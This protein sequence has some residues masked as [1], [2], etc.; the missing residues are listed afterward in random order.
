MEK[1][2]SR[3]IKLMQSKNYQ[4]M[5]KSELAR[6][7]QI[8][9]DERSKMRS[10][11]RK[12][13]SEGEIS[14]GKK[15][16]FEL[17]KNRKSHLVGTLKFHPK[18]FAWVYLDKRNQGNIDSGF[19]MDKNDRVKVSPRHTGVAMDD[20]RVEVKVERT[21][22]PEWVQHVNRRRG[23]KHVKGKKGKG[24]PKPKVSE[25][26]YRDEASGRV[27]KILERRNPI[28]IGTYLE[29]R[30][31]KFVQPESENL[32]GTVELSEPTAAKSGQVV[33]VEMLDWSNRDAMPVGRVTK[34]LGWPDDP[35][36]DI[37]SV[38]HKHG[39]QT[40]FPDAVQK[41]AASVPEVLP[42][43][44]IA[45]RE[46]WRKELI[47]TID[48]GDAKDHDDAVVVRPLKDGWELAV[49]IADVS[50]YV[51]PG[52]ALDL[53]AEKRGNSTYL[54]DRV[55]PMLPEK[56]SNNMCSLRPEVDRLTKC[57]VMRFDQSGKRIKARFCDAVIH[58]KAKLSYEEAQE[59]M[60]GREDGGKI[61]A[62][63]REAW[64]L[65]AVL[66]KR[67][68]DHGSLDLDMP[69]VRVVLDETTKKPVGIRKVDYDESH[70]MIE[71]FMLA[72]NEAVAVEL[73]MQRRNAIFRVH[74]DPDAD[75][76]YEFAEL[77]RIHGF[78]AGDLTNKKH[79][80]EL[81]KAAK[82]SPLE[83]SIKLG[84]LKSLKRAAYGTESLGHYGL[85]KMD[86]CHFT[87]PIRR[88]ADLIVHR[89]LQ[90]VLV[91]RPEKP[92]RV[93][94]MAILEDVAQHISDTE[95]KS[96]EAE[97]ESKKMKMME[98]LLNLTR[99]SNP[100]VFEGI[101]TDVVRM[102]LFVEILDMQVKGLVKVMDFPRGDWRLEM[103]AMRYSGGKGKELAIGQKV[104]VQISRVDIEQQ[105]V[106][107]KI[108]V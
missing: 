38:I 27:V 95:R 18:G 58:S 44:E 101:I 62:S 43:D 98:Y 23:G 10:V 104:P 82:G 70:Q 102:G 28:F 78:R 61:G 52:S 29:K 60:Q 66:R 34:V 14:M 9:S 87:S 94:K 20:D 53:E 81:L 49:H 1:L 22:P 68:F 71:E 103:H 65:A 40:D 91:N 85:A 83:Q 99:E 76:L 41:E 12:L 51:K 80:Q 56:L 4:P 33:A 15:A 31:F 36:V 7:L 48:P 55:I 16:R 64:K 63:L 77:A 25:D 72:A 46:D 105:L 88:Y 47:V 106:D 26:E 39:L 108:V 17:R 79:V 90:G 96:A 74:E 86:Y 107:F 50:H 5:N 57:A 100:P 6:K 8:P 75:R 30:K 54:V 59:M 69:E 19:E 89:A 67:R 21:G 3:I 42:E 97:N 92:D 73:K 35:G 84:L 93:P 32:P 11:L 24:A 2:R 45:R 13:E 37:I